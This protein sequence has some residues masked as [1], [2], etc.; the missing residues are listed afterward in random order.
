MDV[1]ILQYRHTKEISTFHHH[2]AVCD[3]VHEFNAVS[4]YIYVDRQQTSLF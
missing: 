2:F 4:L 3:K 1:V